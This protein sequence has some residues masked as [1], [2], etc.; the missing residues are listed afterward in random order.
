M[1]LL[2][3]PNSWQ[4]PGSL[5]AAD[6]RD[7]Y[8]LGWAIS[9]QVSNGHS[10]PHSLPAQPQASPTH[11]LTT[12]STENPTEQ[13]C[14]AA[15]PGSSHD[16]PPADLSD[17]DESCQRSAASTAH[18][19]NPQAAVSHTGMSST[20]AVP[21]QLPGCTLFRSDTCSASAVLDAASSQ[22]QH[23]H[24]QAD[25]HPVG[26]KRAWTG[27]EGQ[28]KCM[29]VL[30]RARAAMTACERERLSSF[31]HGLDRKYAATVRACHNC[32]W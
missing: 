18:A 7:L 8:D 17:G 20:Q 26:S 5:G 12:D 2:I 25:A 23:T 10:V 32:V 9:R 31:L 14:D 29:L 21:E 3:H 30:I 13:Q 19:S 6:D 15:Q 28:L 22:Q 24:I 11:T 27:G 4:A 1:R 16:P